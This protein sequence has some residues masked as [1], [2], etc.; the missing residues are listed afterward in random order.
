MPAATAGAPSA[1]VLAA[2]DDSAM[3]ALV[4]DAA[5]RLAAG[6]G[7]TVHVVHAQEGA[8]A[9]D[10][11]IDAEDL[12][13]ARAV[14]ARQLDRLAAR[15]IPAVGHVLLHAADHG[16][17]GRLVA[18][19][20]DSIGA[21]TIVLGAPSHG[22][23]PA[24]MDASASRELWRHAHSHILVINPVAAALTS[25]ASR[26]GEPAVAAPGGSSRNGSGAG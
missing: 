15:S 24:L 1:V 19:Y 18:E 7:A 2:V 26:P 25:P 23:L 12:A 5:A 11:G 3:A 4:T 6:G 14:V 8:T 13:A 21:A 10:A 20:A 17:A 22:G 16:A 9:G